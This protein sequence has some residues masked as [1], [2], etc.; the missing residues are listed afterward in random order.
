[1]WG[2]GGGIPPT[3][4]LDPC[5]IKRQQFFNNKTCFISFTGAVDLSVVQSEQEGRG[6]DKVFPCVLSGVSKDSLRDQAK[7]VSEV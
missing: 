6:T 5:K 2:G 4:P 7:E 1:M 3:H